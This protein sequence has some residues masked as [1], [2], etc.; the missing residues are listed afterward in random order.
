MSLPEAI[1]LEVLEGLRDVMEEDFDDLL[2]DYL[3]QCDELW[4]E[5]CAHFAAGDMALLRRSAHTFKGSC[6]SIG[7]EPLMQQMK[8]LEAAAA[9]GE[10]ETV[11]QV[12]AAAE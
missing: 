6:L 12:I 1:E 9:A 7:A 8:A 10:R 2:N 5:T 3:T 4:R 11:A